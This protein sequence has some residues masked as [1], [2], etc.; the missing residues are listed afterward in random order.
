MSYV[1]EGP[2]LP[3]YFCFDASFACFVLLCLLLRR[4]GLIVPFRF[5]V[6]RPGGCAHHRSAVDLACIRGAQAAHRGAMLQH[7]VA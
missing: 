5:M 4:P 1:H 6:H 3:S 7:I 2:T